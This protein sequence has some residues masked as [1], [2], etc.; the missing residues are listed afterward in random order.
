[1]LADYYQYPPAFTRKEGLIFVNLIDFDMLYGHRRDIPGFAS[2]LEEAD[3]AIG[4]IMNSM[5]QDDLLIL[6][7]RLLIDNRQ[8]RKIVHESFPILVVDEFQDTDPVQWEIIKLIS[9]ILIISI[10]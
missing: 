2:A 3:E 10:I 7:L 6:T 5:N 4:T 9:I 8:V 1:M